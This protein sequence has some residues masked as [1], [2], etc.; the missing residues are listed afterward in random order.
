MGQPFSMKSN[1]DLLMKRSEQSYPKGS[2]SNKRPVVHTEEKAM[3]SKTLS[4][5]R[6]ITV[7]TAFISEKAAR[8][9]SGN[10]FVQ[11]LG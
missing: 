3:A 7:Y 6:L 4:I 1:K 9:G 8:H 5:F 10:T 11:D 2:R